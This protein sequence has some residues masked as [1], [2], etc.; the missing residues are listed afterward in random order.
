MNDLSYH[1]DLEDILC[2]AEA[3]YLQIKEGKNAK[4]MEILGLP[5]PPISNALEDIESTTRPISNHQ[6][7][8][9]DEEELEKQCEAALSLQ[10]L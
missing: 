8:V 7:G 4:V 5:L 3:I 2:K 10:Y 1:I 9:H 6:C